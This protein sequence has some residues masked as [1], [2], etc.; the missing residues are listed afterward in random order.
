MGR[1]RFVLLAGAQTLT[2]TH[3]NPLSGV[4]GV[5]R[6]SMCKLLSVGI[7]ALLISACAK[8]D[9]KTSG[10]DAAGLW[11]FPERLVWVQIDNLGR[12][13]QCRIDIDGSVISSRGKLKEDNIIEWESVWEPDRIRKVGDT[14]YLEGPFGNFGF[15]KTDNSMIKECENPL[16]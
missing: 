8:M 13:F 16:S 11:Q 6:N 5:M 1:R 9:T 3:A 10:G 14:I 7:M 15:V 12:V 2:Q 4:L